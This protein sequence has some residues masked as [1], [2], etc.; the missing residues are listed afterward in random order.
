MLSGV[1]LACVP[2]TSPRRLTLE[3]GNMRR[4]LI[5]TGTVGMTAVIPAFASS[6]S[7][8]V[9]TSMAGSPR[10]QRYSRRAAPTPGRWPSLSPARIQR[11]GRVG[12]KAA[13]R[14]GSAARRL[15]S[16]PK[17]KNQPCR[18]N[19]G[20]APTARGRHPTVP[21][22]WPAPSTFSDVLVTYSGHAPRERDRQAPR[23][24]MSTC[25]ACS[26]ASVPARCACQARCP[27]AGAEA[28]EGV[29]T[30]VFCHCACQRPIVARSS[31]ISALCSAPAGPRGDAPTTAR[32][33]SGTTQRPCQNT[34]LRRVL[35]INRSP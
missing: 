29:V 33:G 31:S 14:S 8:V 21:A 28:P 1:R 7:G 16:P 15:M 24:S 22:A 18:S 3:P 13:A 27:D 11:I 35:H 30:C 32:P 25:S 9:L 6:V 2:D 10:S 17:K 23:T 19:V 26:C 34:L 4:W 5:E 20:P 12:A